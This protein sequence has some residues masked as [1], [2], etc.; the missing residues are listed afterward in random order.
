VSKEKVMSAGTFDVIVIGAGPA[1]EVLAGR[2]ASKGHEVAIVEADLVGGECS[3]YA[4]MPSKALLRPAEALAEARRV[5]GAAQAVTGELDVDAV[6]ARRDQITGG[7]DDSGQVPWLES[8]GVRLIRGH[9][10]LDGERQ[11][12]VGAVVLRARRAVVIATGSSAAMP[13]VPGLAQARPWTN[14]EATVAS[15]IPVRLVILGGGVVGVEMAQAY[16]TLGSRVTVI[17]AEERLLTREEPFA[18]EELRQ[19]LIGRGVDVRT[20]VRAVA[21]RRDGPEVTVTLSDGRRI[22]GEEIL[23]AVG[24]RPRTQDLGL[25]T[26][27]LQPGQ[28][29]EVTDSLA[30]PGVPWL[31]AIGDV[32][33]RSLLTHMGK[34]QAHVLSEIL[35]GRPGTVSGDDASAPRVI[36]T[37]PQVAAVGLTLQGALDLGMDARAYDVPSSATAGGAFHGTGTPG[38]ARIIVD[39]QRGVIVGATFTGTEVAE[40]LQAATIAI[41][42]K[43]PVELLWQAVPAFPTRSEIWLKLLER[44]EADLP[45]APADAGRP[46]AKPAIASQAQP[47]RHRQEPPVA[48]RR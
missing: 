44:R 5:P 6:L 18:G 17:E 46:T 25:Q 28:P 29:L 15:T 1:G 10:R 26:I 12:R 16:A 48:A 13:P 42:G 9:G 2:L 3:Y 32:N 31:Y 30:I 35:D 37:D 7:L 11:V 27:G 14:R 24:R 39:E 33:G 23:V 40:W 19:A 4:C 21:V 8:R 20:G 41:V 38:T 22:R 43:T 34:Y 47:A 36:F 45:S